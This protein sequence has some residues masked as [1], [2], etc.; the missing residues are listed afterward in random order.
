VAV[1]SRKITVPVRAAGPAAAADTLAVK[2]TVWPGSE[3]LPDEVR[4]VL[5]WAWPTDWPV[6]PL[7][8]LKLLSP[9]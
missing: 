3:G 4:L 8:P 5:V 2:V 6:V 7:P 9:E 1:P